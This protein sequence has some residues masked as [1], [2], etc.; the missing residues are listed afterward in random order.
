[1][2]TTATRIVFPERDR[3]ELEE[4]DLPPVGPLRPGLGSGAPWR[5]CH[6]KT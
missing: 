3:V 2:S 6:A 1:M 4:F 5:F